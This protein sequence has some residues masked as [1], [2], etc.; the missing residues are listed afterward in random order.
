MTRYLIIVNPTADKGGAAHR[1]PLIHERLKSLGLEYDLVLTER[2]GHAVELTQQAILDG[3]DVV[4]AAGGDGTANEVINGIMRSRQTGKRSIVMGVLP[5]GRGNDFAFGMDAP[6]DFEESIRVLAAG[7][8]RPIDIGFIQGG[9][10]PEGRFFGNGVGIGFDAVVGFVAARSRLTGFFGYLIAALKT[11]FIYFQPPTVEITLDDQ[12]ICQPSLMVSI[13]NGRRMG[14]GFMM[15]PKSSPQDGVFDL[16]IASTVSRLRIL[17]LIPHFIR[18]DQEGHPAIQFQRSRRVHVRAV[19]G[20][21]PTHA[22]GE[23]ICTQAQELTIELFPAQ[24]E[25]IYS[26]VDGAS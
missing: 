13:M 18:G 5:I 26:P 15:A 22:D 25:F 4:V 17:A 8:T 24:F 2:P 12:R 7:K 3:Y 20:S 11:I 1:V 14:G 19:A 23:T 10:Y 9:D 16:C 21:L 6:T